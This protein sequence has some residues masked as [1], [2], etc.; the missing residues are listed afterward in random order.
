MGRRGGLLPG[1][2]RFAAALPL[3]VPGLVLGLAFILFFNHPANPLGFLYGTLGILVLNSL[4]HFY[5][6]AHLTAVTAIPPARPG[7]PGGGGLPA[8][9]GLG[10]LRPGD[11]ADLPAGDPRHRGLPVRQ[12]DDDGERGDFLYGP[13][14]KLASIAVLHMDEAGQVSA[15]AAMAVTI[16]GVTTAVKVAHVAL[17]GVVDRATQGWRKR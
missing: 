2:V 12:R 14:T 6:V 15:A 7:I 11:G 9:A 3:A 13:D 8:G 4:V 5:T 16:L 17:G 1:L 10:D